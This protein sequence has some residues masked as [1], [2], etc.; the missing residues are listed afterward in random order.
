MSAQSI[1]PVQP[2]RY[3]EFV[4]D[5]KFWIAPFKG[6]NTIKVWDHDIQAGKLSVEGPKISLREDVESRVWRSS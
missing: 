2:E 3:L 1:M 6:E 4:P 5:G